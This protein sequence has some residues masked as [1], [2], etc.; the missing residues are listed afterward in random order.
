MAKNVF[1]SLC[2][3][4]LF[5]IVSPRFVA[6][7]G[8]SASKTLGLEFYSLAGKHKERLEWRCAVYS[9]SLSHFFD[10]LFAEVEAEKKELVEELR[11]RAAR[12]YRDGLRYYQWHRLA[13]AKQYWD[14]AQNHIL[15]RQDPLQQK[16]ERSLMY[17]TEPHSHL[18][19]EG[20][21][22]G[23]KG[24]SGGDEIRSF[25]EADDAPQA[26]LALKTILRKSPDN[27]RAGKMTATLQEALKKEENYGPSKE[28]EEKFVKAKKLLETNNYQQLKQAIALFN[29]EELKPPFYKQIE[30]A[31]QAAEAKLNKELEP[32]LAQYDVILTPSSAHPEP[33]E[34]SNKKNPDLIAIGHDLRNILRDYSPNPKA[35]DLL[36]KVYTRLDEKARP[37]LMQADTVLQLE[38]CQAAVELFA[39]VKN[40]SVFPEVAAW[41]TAHK[42]LEACKKSVEV[43]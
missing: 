32:K 17:I 40:V 42:N 41:Q 10:P 37:L 4:L 1:W 30:D 5:V 3:S 25:L 20:K 22:D 36:Q 28:L 29:S 14:L 27:E 19:E 9:Y 21:G 12:Y 7:E 34:G 2:L 31:L 26:L 6:G 11:H 18:V 35:N 24:E 33:V 13:E 38:G 15:N 43:L 8:L 39:N 23:K 16:I